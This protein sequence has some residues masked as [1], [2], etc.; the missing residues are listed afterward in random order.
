ME[1]THV[2]RILFKKT[3]IRSLENK[4]HL[5]QTDD[6][7]NKKGYVLLIEEIQGFQVFT[8][9]RKFKLIFRWGRVFTID[10]VGNQED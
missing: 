7:M 9:K 4:T 10:S 8:E 6:F 1:H 5:I 2:D 3:T